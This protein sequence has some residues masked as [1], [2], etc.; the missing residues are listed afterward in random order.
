MYSTGSFVSA[1]STLFLEM[2]AKSF[3]MHVRE[4]T[5]Q[6]PQ[7]FYLHPLL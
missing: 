4:K 5:S 6:Y 2:L 1:K 3:S 7:L